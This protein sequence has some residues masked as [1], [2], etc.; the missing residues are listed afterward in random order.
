MAKAT[1]PSAVFTW[2]MSMCWPSAAVY[3]SIIRAAAIL[4]LRGRGENLVRDRHL[5]GV[6]RDAAAVHQVLLIEC[7]L[8]GAVA[9]VDVLRQTANGAVQSGSADEERNPA[10]QA[11]RLESLWRELEAKFMTLVRARASGAEQAHDTGARG[12]DLLGVRHGVNLYDFVRGEHLVFPA[13]LMAR[14]KQR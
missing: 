5:P 10:A 14:P 7:E 13:F 9:F 12:R 2:A 3:S 8:A 6:D 1:M 11:E 4:V